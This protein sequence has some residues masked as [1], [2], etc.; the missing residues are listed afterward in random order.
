MLN[1]LLS[2]P[3]FIFVVCMPLGLIVLLTIIPICSDIFAFYGEWSF[4]Q[5][6]TKPKELL[7]R[8]EDDIYED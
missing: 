7:D 8:W 6:E 5:W 3:F 4:K 1:K 2:V